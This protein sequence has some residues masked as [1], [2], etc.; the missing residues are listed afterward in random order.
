MPRLSNEPQRLVFEHPIDARLHRFL[1]GPGADVLTL[2]QWIPEAFPSL[3]D[4]LANESARKTSFFEQLVPDAPHAAFTRGTLRRTLED[5]RWADVL[6][7]DDRALA[8]AS[9]PS[10]GTYPLLATAADAMAEVFAEADIPAVARALPEFHGTLPVFVANGG[11]S[12]VFRQL[13]QSLGAKLCEASQLSDGSR[14]REAL[15]VDGAAS[16]ALPRVIATVERQVR[17]NRRVL[18]LVAGTPAQRRWIESALAANASVASVAEPA[19]AKTGGSIYWQRLRLFRELPTAERIRWARRFDRLER[20]GSAN[21]N[22]KATATLL[23][24]MRRDNVKEE[25]IRSLE[26]LWQSAVLREDGAMDATAPVLVASVRPIGS[27]YGADVIVVVGDSA[28]DSAPPSLLTPSDLGKLANAGFSVMERPSSTAAIESLRRPT[29][30]RRKIFTLGSDINAS[31]T[32]AHLRA[33]DPTPTDARW[34]LDGLED[35]PGRASATQLATFAECPAKYVAR[36]R[37]RW[38][39]PEPPENEFHRWVGT[40]THALLEHWHRQHP[41]VPTDGGA[42][43]LRELFPTARTTAF[44]DGDGPPPSMETAVARRALALAARGLALEPSLAGRLGVKRTL[45]VEFGFE[46]RSGPWSFAGRYDRVVELGNGSKIVLDYKTGAT[47]FTPAHA[48]S[49]DDPQ[50]ALYWLSGVERF[51]DKFAGVLFVSLKEASAER[52]VLRKQLVG[53][54]AMVR[55]HVLDEAKWN[56]GLF[57]ARSAV[58]AQAQRLAEERRFEPTPSVLACERCSYGTLCRRRFGDA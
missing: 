29:G 27:T 41:D 58:N 57:A 31:A 26:A 7:E 56:D 42:K 18:V 38:N 53:T 8:F 16:A 33:G 19:A 25:S 12:T 47:A 49:G 40:L 51:G 3:A 15:C 21:A 32:R 9:L 14:Q 13:V 43:E 39:P 46:W 28:V 48:T 20:Q 55:G 22:A 24:E 11:G 6:T 52:G 35:R 37:W 36:Y 34:T 10:T 54:P 17:R 4:A 50:G 23:D 30:T 2:D 44:R 45:G 5:L 1:A